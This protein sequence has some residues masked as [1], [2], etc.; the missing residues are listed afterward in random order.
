MVDY[1]EKE[2]RWIWKR[3]IENAYDLA[4]ILKLLQ[5]LQLEDLGLAPKYD[6]IL[7]PAVSV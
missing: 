3:G 5:Q 4:E 1:L 7:V 2:N 6:E